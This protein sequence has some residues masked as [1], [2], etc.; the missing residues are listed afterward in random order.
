VS[1][2]WSSNGF[3]CSGFIWAENWEQQQQLNQAKI[4]TFFSFHF[5][6]NIDEATPDVIIENMS[7]FSC[8]GWVSKD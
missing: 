4:Q 6:L 2:L 5:S 7:I 3:I 1:Q 8:S